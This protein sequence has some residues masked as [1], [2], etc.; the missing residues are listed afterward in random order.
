MNSG[1]YRGRH[2]GTPAPE[3]RPPWMQHPKKKR[4]ARPRP[5]MPRTIRKILIVVIILA[6]AAA[7]VYI[8]LMLTPDVARTATIK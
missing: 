8:Y 7:G 5:E 4:K 2:A 6:V 3:S 1:E